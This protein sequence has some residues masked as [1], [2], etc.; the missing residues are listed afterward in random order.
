MYDCD[1]GQPAGNNDYRI[2]AELPDII[3]SP[4]LKHPHF[5]QQEMAADRSKV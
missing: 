1:G 5:V 2:L 4:A 3:A